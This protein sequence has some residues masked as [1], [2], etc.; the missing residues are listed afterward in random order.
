M[1]RP[2]AGRARRATIDRFEHDVAVLQV[3]GREVRCARADLPPEAREGDGVDLK[4]GVVDD[5][6]TERLR[7][8]VREARARAQGRKPPTGGFDL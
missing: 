8:E 4:R 6:A 2:K 7:D 5:E 3:E 1:T